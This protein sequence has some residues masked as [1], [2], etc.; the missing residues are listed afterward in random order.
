MPSHEFYVYSSDVLTYDAGT[1]AFTLDPGYDYTTGRLRI[2]VEDDDATMNGD[3]NGDNVGDDP[4]QTG[5]AY[6]MVGNVLATGTIYAPAYA[7][8]EGSEGGY[9]FI[10]R[11]EV[12]GFLA[13]Y[14]S[15]TPLTP[16][17]VYDV[18][19][20]GTYEE[21]HAFYESHSVP[22][23]SAGTLIDTTDGRVAVEEIA[24]GCNVLTLDHG[25]QPVLWAG[26]RKVSA[27]AALR[28]D[29]VR[30]ITFAVD[31]FDTG[32]PDRPL[33]LSGDHRVLLEGADIQYHFGEDEVLA[34]ARHIPRT[35]DTG[36]EVHPITY[37]HLLF[38]RHEVIRANGLWCE[39]LFLGKQALLRLSTRDR[40][41]IDALL[42]G[43]WDRG[44]TA[45]R[46]L[47]NWECRVLTR[48]RTVPQPDV[49]SGGAA[50]RRVA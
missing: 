19:N 10:D 13:G 36:G 47:K 7:S 22:C 38:S 46:C 15:S 6:D 1:G 27:R 45:R 21:Q 14:V 3:Q 4:D 35:G 50:A 43:A 26:K 49:L 23:F 12:D 18:T 31:A 25:P 11:I 24:A 48:R 29:G 41:T 42:D 20:S 2:V 8:L 5:V 32:A 9:Y 44:R 37:H 40:W 16:G 39:S 17:E 28:D 34:A 33:S 30:P